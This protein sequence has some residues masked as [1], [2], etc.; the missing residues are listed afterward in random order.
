MLRLVELIIRAADRT[1]FTV[2]LNH[3]APPPV[4]RSTRGKPTP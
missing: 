4:E 1:G 3:M 2:T